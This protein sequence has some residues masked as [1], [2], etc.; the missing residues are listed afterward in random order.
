[1]GNPAEYG[2]EE[3]SPNYGVS[4][5]LNTYQPCQAGQAFS[6]QAMCLGV[7]NIIVGE[8]MFYKQN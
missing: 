3:A 2:T 5:S 4:Q 1:V 7:L 8:V 6:D